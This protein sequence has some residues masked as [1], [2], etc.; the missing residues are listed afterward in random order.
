MS[1]QKSIV[2][3]D[4]LSVSFATDGGDVKAIDGVTLD[5]HPREVLAIVGES[6][7]GKS[8]TARTIIGL[9]PETATANGAVVLQSKSG[10]EHNIVRTSGEKMRQLRGQEVAM[11]FQEAS[12]ALNPVFPVGWQIAEGIRAHTK[13]KRK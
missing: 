5:V 10:G 8:V 9:L 1:D 12:T 11:V 4:D 6:G 13:V 7:S 2:A 3:I